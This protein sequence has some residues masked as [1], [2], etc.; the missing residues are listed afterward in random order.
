MAK[1][2]ENCR[3]QECTFKPTLITDHTK[4]TKRVI[5]PRAP[6]PKTPSSVVNRLSKDVRER[7]ERLEKLS[8]MHNEE[9][10]PKTGRPLFRPKTGRKPMKERPHS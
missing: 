1:V 5:Q 7:E 9:V 2:Y 3:D 4:L 10:D 8:K 6:S